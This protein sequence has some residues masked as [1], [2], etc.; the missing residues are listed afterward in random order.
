LF[1]VILSEEQQETADVLICHPERSEEPQKQVH[2][3]CR[4]VSDTRDRSVLYGI[5]FAYHSAMN[6]AMF[7]IF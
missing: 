2:Y 5:V 7:F 4:S 3:I 6:F 1:I